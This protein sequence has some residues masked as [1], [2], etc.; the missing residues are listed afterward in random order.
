MLPPLHEDHWPAYRLRASGA[1]QVPLQRPTH[2]VKTSRPLRD[3]FLVLVHVWKVKGCEYYEP[4]MPWEHLA[5]KGGYLIRPGM[6]YRGRTYV[7]RRYVLETCL[8]RR[9][10]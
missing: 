9:S 3:P 7:G 4:A 1:A 5:T 8:S 10:A 6:T 2:P